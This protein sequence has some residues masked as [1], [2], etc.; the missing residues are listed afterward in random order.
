[1]SYAPL[2]LTDLPRYH[3]QIVAMKERTPGNADD[4]ERN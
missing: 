3:S 4:D 1:M 2:V